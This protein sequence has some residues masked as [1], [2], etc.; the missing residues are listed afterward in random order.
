MHDP[1]VARLGQLND[2]D[3]VREGFLARY[4]GS[5]FAAYNS[6]LQLFYRWCEDNDLDPLTVKRVHIDLWLRH[7]REER[8]NK[9]STVYRRLMALKSMYEYAVDE[10]FIE[11]SPARAIRP[12]HPSYDDL[13]PI[14]LSPNEFQRLIAAATDPT[15]YALIAIMGYL[16]LRVSEACDINIGDYDDFHDDV[17]VVKF[18]G[19]GGVPGIAP[20]SDELH[21]A[22]K[23]AA[24]DRTEGPLLLQSDGLRL[25]RRSAGRVVTRV[26]KAAGL[27]KHVTPHCLRHTFV[28]SAIDAGVHL[29]SV[30]LAAR[31]LSIK[32]TMVYDRHRQVPMGSHAAHD[33]AAFLNKGA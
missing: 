27:T 21:E 22:F 13:P 31:H 20:V 8:H 18:M 10:E 19:K 28:V 9:D 1:I 30:Q 11:R 32:N 24:G 14:A 12:K 25:T 26:A 16:G 17:R 6:D 2:A 33:V 15:D 7:L 29:R 23:A 3:L 4:S 5:S